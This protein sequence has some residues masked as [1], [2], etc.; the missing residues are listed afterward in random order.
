MRFRYSLVAMFVAVAVA[1]LMVVAG[2][3]SGMHGIAGVWIGLFGL[4]VIWRSGATERF[5]TF[6]PGALILLVALLI[7]AGALRP[8]VF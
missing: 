1:A 5:T 6:L 8:A 3:A 7:A 4:A 2:Q